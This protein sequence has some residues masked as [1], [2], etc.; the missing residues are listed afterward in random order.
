[1]G[2]RAR[3]PYG[4]ATYVNLGLFSTDCQQL[5]SVWFIHLLSQ[6]GI[7]YGSLHVKTCTH[8]SQWVT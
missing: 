6:H 4:F 5:T 3:H 1:M 7:T 2:A 8:P